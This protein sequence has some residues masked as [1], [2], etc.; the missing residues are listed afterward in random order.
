MFFPVV[1]DPLVGQ[2]PTGDSW[3]HNPIPGYAAETSRRA[4]PEVTAGPR[5]EKK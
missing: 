3:T 5:F 4:G 1:V 2:S